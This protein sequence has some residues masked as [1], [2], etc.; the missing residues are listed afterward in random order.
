MKTQV[1]HHQMFIGG[2][3][4]DSSGHEA[5]GIVD[6]GLGEVIATVPKGTDKDVDRAVA[7]ARKAYEEVW[8]DS[9]PRE[10]SEMLLKIADVILEHGEELARIESENVGKP[11]AT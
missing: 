9:T 6:P 10:R 1:R 4:V 7:A 11:L 8:F 3:W 5:Q 2:E